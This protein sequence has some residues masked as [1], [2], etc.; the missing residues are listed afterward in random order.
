MRKHRAE[1]RE[2][3]YR[4]PWKYGRFLKMRPDQRERAGSER[5]NLESR[6]YKFTRDVE[7][8]HREICFLPYRE[9]PKGHDVWEI[10]AGDEPRDCD[11][12]VLEE[13]MRL[14]TGL[15]IPLG[16]LRPQLCLVPTYEG[17]R[18]HM[19]LILTA[20]DRD[21]VLDSNVVM[22]LPYPAFRYR[23]Y[24]RW[25]TDEKWQRPSFYDKPA[26]WDK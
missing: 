1:M 2:R 25:Y 22:M 13:R 11:D 21:L 6:P 15:G 17:W 10:K 5:V 16:A 20:T 23:W 24:Y 12:K 3:L 4:A 19:V 7:R 9:D 26:T 14:N 8:I 18:G